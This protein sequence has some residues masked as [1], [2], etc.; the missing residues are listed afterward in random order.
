[1]F[2]DFC[3]LKHSLGINKSSFQQPFGSM[4]FLR[5]FRS[6]SV[7]KAKAIGSMRLGSRAKV[8]R[9]ASLEESRGLSVGWWWLNPRFKGGVVVVLVTG[10]SFLLYM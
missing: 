9:Q 3:L 2:G 1:M 4:T 7:T 10:V 8:S 5:N 6:S